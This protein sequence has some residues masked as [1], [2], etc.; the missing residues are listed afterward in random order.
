[1]ERKS[2]PSDLTDAQWQKIATLLP[3]AKGGRT[4]RPRTYPLREIWNAI[5]YQAQTGCAWRYLPHDLPPWEN[6]WEHFCRWRDDG[7]IAQVHDALR[8]QV[9]IQAGREPTPSAAII[10]SQ[11]VKTPQKGGANGYDAGKKIKGR[12]R[13]LAVDTMG[14]LLAVVV[15]CAGIQDRDGAKWVCEKLHGKFP[16]LRLSWADGGY[17]GELVAWVASFA[18]WMLEIVKRRN[19][20]TGVVV[21]PRRWVVERPFAWLSQ[22]RRLSKDYEETPASSEAWIRLAMIHLMVRRL[23]SDAS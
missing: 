11:T 1:M 19:D 17:A 22:C 20:G 3:Q 13:H 4:G 15:H 5:F 14:L 9:R 2:Y 7:T 23:A 21:L 12:K 16:R 6:V 18:D 8:E 10:D